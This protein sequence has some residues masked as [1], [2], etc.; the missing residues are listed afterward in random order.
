MPSTDN[1][2][3]QENLVTDGVWCQY[4][5]LIG[6]L[7]VSAEEWLVE[8]IYHENRWLRKYEW[9]EYQWWLRMDAMPTDGS[10]GN[11][12][13]RKNN[14]SSTVPTSISNFYIIFLF[15]FKFL[16]WQRWLVPMF[17]KYLTDVSRCLRLPLGSFLTIG[18]I[19]SEFITNGYIY[20]CRGIEDFDIRCQCISIG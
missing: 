5:D 18:S 6:T 17:S 1:E 7:T 4:Q 10:N 2:L 19:S 16:I 12:C 13:H 9:I 11:K 3:S 8:P 15:F 14:D 20:I